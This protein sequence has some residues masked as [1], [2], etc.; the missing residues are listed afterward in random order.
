MTAIR[1][2]VSDVDGTLV[3]DD[4]RLAG[5]T[6]AAVA[7][8]RAA[9]IG[10]AL[11]SARPASGLRPIIEALDLDGAVSAFNGGL[12][13]RCDGTILFHETIAGDAAREAIEAAREAPVATWLFAHGHWHAS[14]PEG[15]HTDRE[16][17][18]AAQEPRPLGD[19]AAL[20]DAADKITFVC[21]SPDVLDGLEARL[22]DALGTR[23]TVARSQTYYLDVTAA[24]ADK[25]QG[26]ARLAEAHGVPLSETAA[27]GD[28][29]NDVP[30][31]VR[32]ALSIAMGNA[33][34]P[35]QA[36]A[37]MVTATN[38]ALGVARAIDGI[39]LHPPA[40]RGAA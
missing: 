5:E 14:D 3:D 10:F 4:K 25:G 7:R 19:P 18:S 16:R 35:V 11:I 38:E 20:L 30:M 32:A 12:V 8:L 39:I 28:Q 33:P 27:I 31:L 40:E 2:L 37:H 1:L 9:G 22:K 6:V 24:G 36:K 21:D 29:A 26:I 34:A 23:A 17:V 15:P 13:Y